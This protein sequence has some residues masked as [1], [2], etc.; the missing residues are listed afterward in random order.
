[1]ESLLVAAIIIGV[2]NLYRYWKQNQD[3]EDV[4]EVQEVTPSADEGTPSAT[5]DLV[6]STLDKMRIEYS[7]E[8]E[9]RIR[10]TFQGET[11]M[12]DAHN[13]CLFINVYDPWWFDLPMHG[14]IEDFARMQ[15][16]VNLANCTGTCTVLY[17]YNEEEG[18]IGVHSRK[19]IIFVP[20]ITEL[21]KYL[22]SVF[23]AFFKTQRLVL[24][25]MDKLKNQEV[26]NQR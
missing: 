8:D 18:L 4:V 11:F 16:A 9:L 26:V 23:D 14:D 12:I 15:K 21:D 20:Q 7:E 6:L 10:L 3:T 13:D 17:T 19:N 25:E 22:A 2:I 5:R 24:A 1:M